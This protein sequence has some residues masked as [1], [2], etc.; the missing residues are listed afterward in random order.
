MMFKLSS[1]GHKLNMMNSIR[2]PLE[3]IVTVHLDILKV[4]VHVWNKNH[5]SD[6]SELVFIIVHYSFQGTTFTLNHIPY[7]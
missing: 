1:R 6:Y 4:H 7:L 3:V 5:Q 2:P